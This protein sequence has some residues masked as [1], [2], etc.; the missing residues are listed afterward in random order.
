M[1]YEI[2]R[3]NEKIAVGISARTKNSDEDMS[4]VIGSLWQ[5]FYQGGVYESIP[6][7]VNNKA[8]GIYSDYEEDVNGKYSVT[9][10]CEVA[11][12]LSPPEGTVTAR[13][14]S[15]RYA[16]F[17]VRGHMQTAVAEFWNK[18]WKMDLDRSYEFDFE[19]YQNDDFENAEIHVYISLK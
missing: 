8:L 1:D 3:L 11:G 19:E 13:I 2:V 5:K 15:G 7:K 10:A 9:V 16:K 18:L 14:L 12:A 6:N 4:M 17:I